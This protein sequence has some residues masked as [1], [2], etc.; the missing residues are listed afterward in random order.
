MENLATARGANHFPRPVPQKLLTP[1]ATW[2]PDELRGPRNV[3]GGTS[4]EAATTWNAAAIECRNNVEAVPFA[5]V[6][7]GGAD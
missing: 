2:V 7:L 1:S 4:C 5:V 3:V 6:A